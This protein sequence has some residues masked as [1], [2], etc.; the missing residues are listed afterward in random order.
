MERERGGGFLRS[1]G[2]GV[3]A[4]ARRV[5]LGGGGGGLN[6]LL[7]DDNPFSDEASAL[8][9]AFDINVAEV[10][11]RDRHEGFACG[12]APV[13]T[14]ARAPRVAVAAQIVTDR[15]DMREKVPETREALKRD[16]SNQSAKRGLF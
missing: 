14:C 11:L 13:C 7:F 12:Q 1:G 10:V 3:R 9:F 4:G 16:I 5:W 15:D 6:M 8:W 2:S